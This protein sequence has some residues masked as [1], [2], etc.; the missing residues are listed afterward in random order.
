MSAYTL[1]PGGSPLLPVALHTVDVTRAWGAG[2]APFLEDVVRMACVQTTIQAMLYLGSG[3]AGACFWSLDF[4]LLL[5]YVVLGV[6][7]YWLVW[8]RLVAFA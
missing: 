5:A 7:I 2:Y 1:Y 8:R 4:V 6:G 3:Q